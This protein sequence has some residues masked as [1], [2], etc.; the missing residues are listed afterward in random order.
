MATFLPHLAS[1][2]LHREKVL[3]ISSQSAVNEHSASL[4]VFFYSIGLLFSVA[5]E[6]F[7][8]FLNVAKRIR[9]FFTSFFY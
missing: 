6:G 9:R 7:K 2:S 4:A 8:C 5:Q 1:S 3:L